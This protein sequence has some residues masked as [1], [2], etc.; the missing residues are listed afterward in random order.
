VVDATPDGSD[1]VAQQV[2]RSYLPLGGAGGL[3][4]SYPLTEQT[5]LDVVVRASVFFGSPATSGGLGNIGGVSLVAAYR[6]G[7]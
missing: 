6:F 2:T 1:P 5:W 4:L 7:L 3:G